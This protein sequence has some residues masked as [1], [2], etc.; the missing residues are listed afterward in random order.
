MRTLKSGIHGSMMEVESRS[1]AQ[2]RIDGVVASPQEIAV[3]NNIMENTDCDPRDL[4]SSRKRMIRD[5]L[6]PGRQSPQVRIISS[7]AGPSK[8]QGLRGRENRGR[9]LG[10]LMSGLRRIA[11]LASN[12]VKS[13]GVHPVKSLRSPHIQF[14]KILLGTSF[15]PPSFILVDLAIQKQV[16]SLAPRRSFRNW[17][18]AEPIRRRHAVGGLYSL[19][20]LFFSAKTKAG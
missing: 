15:S 16:P 5:T 1:L 7:S 14:Q 6:A 11:P 10:A 4:G 13:F 17:P 20:S 8:T 12:P 2:R 18:E 19:S 3:I 9:Y